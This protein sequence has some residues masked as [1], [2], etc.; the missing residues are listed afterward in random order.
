MSDWRYNSSGYWS[1]QGSSHEPQYPSTIGEE[2]LEDEQAY[3][4]A[5][6][7]YTYASPQRF[8]PQDDQQQVYWTDEP[9]TYQPEDQTAYDQQYYQAPDDQGNV[10]YTPTTYTGSKDVNVRCVPFPPHAFTP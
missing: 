9:Q 2:V 3:A 7:E 4:E 1:N 10:P 5:T 8:Q 6:G